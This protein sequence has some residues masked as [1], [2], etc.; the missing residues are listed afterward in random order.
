MTDLAGDKRVTTEADAIER[1]ILEIET[2]L[3]A[4]LERNARVDLNKSW[5]TS[6]VRLFSVTMVTYL[7]MTLVFSVLHSARPLLDALVPTTGFFLSTL[8]L[9]FVRRIWQ[10][11]LKR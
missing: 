5:E 7:T 6:W 3:A 2:K 8:S 4:V 1:R 9:P 11:R 10:G